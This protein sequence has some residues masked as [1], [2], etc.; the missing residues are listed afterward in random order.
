MFYTQLLPIGGVI[1]TTRT[2]PAPKVIK[3]PTG[4]RSS[5]VPQKLCKE[6]QVSCS[7]VKS[8]NT[9]L[10][11]KSGLLTVLKANV[12]TFNLLPLGKSHEM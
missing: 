5:F 12:F 6:K 3:G 2:K 10:G 7:A 1:P 11:R 8:E 9:S 4:V